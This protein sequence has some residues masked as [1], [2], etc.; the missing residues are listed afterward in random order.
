MK[1]LPEYLL[2]LYS[3]SGTLSIAISQAVMGA[4]L[5]VAAFDRGRTMR[6][7]RTGLEGPVLAWA[8]AAAL[9]TL[10]STAPVESLGK[11]RKILLFGMAW[12]APAVV[13]RRWGLGRLFM[14]LLFGAG[15]TSL[16][17]VLTF[18]LQGGPAL[19]VR[20]NGFHGFYL[21]NSG[22][23]LLC[24]FPAVLFALCRTSGSSYRW[25]AGLAAVSILAAQ[26]LGRLPGAWIGTA[27]GFLFL[28]FRRRQPLLAGGVIAAALALVLLPGIFQQS[29]RDILD[30][31]SPANVERA[32]V[33]ENGVKLFAEDP[34]TGWGLQD[35]RADYARVKSPDDPDEGHMNS[36]PVQVAASM[37]IPGLLAFGW[38]LVALFRRLAAARKRVLHDT[39][40]R[41]VVEGAEAGLVAFVAA[42]LVEW[43]LGD[44]EILALLFFLVGAA[45]AAERV[46]P[47]PEARPA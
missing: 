29:A 24:T 35:L 12:W 44:S 21:T 19:A 13:G 22:L 26:L 27:A 10:F 16:Y 5:V 31:R 7:M 17:G 38:L 37:G 40:L 39:F 2:N 46:A 47:P 45:I 25:G 18:F 36:V 42:G 32:R 23:L 30:P 3:L 6:W 4:G 9:A 11:M 33:W 20:I 34:L 15:T 14:G 28:A 43:N 1:K 41:S 8:L